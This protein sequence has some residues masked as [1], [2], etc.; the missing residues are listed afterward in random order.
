MGS[1]I[2]HSFIVTMKLQVDMAPPWYH[3]AT[4]HISTIHWWF[5][6][7]ALKCICKAAP[8]GSSFPSCSLSL[9]SIQ[10]LYHTGPAPKSRRM[11]QLIFGSRFFDIKSLFLQSSIVSK[12]KPPDQAE[13]WDTLLVDAG[14]H[15]QPQFSLSL[16]Q[17]KVLS[18]A[19]P[20]SIPAHHI[21]PAMHRSSECAMHPWVGPAS[22]KP[23][24][25]RLILG[26][27]AR[28][29]VYTNPLNPKAGGWYGGF[30][31]VSFNPSFRSL[32][33]SNPDLMPTRDGYQCPNP[34]I[35]HLSF[36]AFSW[37]PICQQRSCPITWAWT[38]D[39]WTNYRSCYSWQGW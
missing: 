17:Q 35:S 1:T 14:R 20:H 10:G 24:L 11:V 29:P 28:L 27:R 8:P 31:R 4:K 5:F 19:T 39:R 21:S 2:S 34:D 9:S 13:L 16:V 6:S 33:M 23:F 26:A 30:I 22:L 32:T 25:K 15:Q 36:S 38:A 18:R 3:P 7:P 12:N 37:F